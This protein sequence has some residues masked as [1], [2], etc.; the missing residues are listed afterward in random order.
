MIISWRISMFVDE[1]SSFVLT[2]VVFDP[3]LAALNPKKHVART[4]RHPPAPAHRRRATIRP[5]EATC[6]TATSGRAG[7]AGHGSRGDLRPMAR[8][9]HGRLLNLMDRRRWL[10]ALRKP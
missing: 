1:N 4:D 10:P 8:G 3:H 7:C 9:G 2:S 6:D 5:T